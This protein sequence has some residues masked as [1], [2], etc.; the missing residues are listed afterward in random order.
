MLLSTGPDDQVPVAPPAGVCGADVATCPQGQCCTVFGFCAMN[1]T[2]TNSSKPRT[3][4]YDFVV[5]WKEGA[6]DGFRRRLIAINGRMPGPTINCNVGD[7]L[8]IRVHN[9]LDAPMSLH[10]HG[11]LQRGTA[12][13]DGVPGVTQRALQPRTSQLYDFLCPTAGAFWYHSHFKE[14]YIDG[15]KGALIV[16]DPSMPR[17]PVETN[18]Q[19]SD[20][21]HVEANK[22]AKYYLSPASGGN[23]VGWGG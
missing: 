1:C 8:I 12:I 13:M 15:M 3:K 23:G 5:A 17:F 22:L 7:R 19:L 20:W 10:W 11:I 21:Y 14:Q 16:H 9:K 2:T 6:P 4:R 18:V